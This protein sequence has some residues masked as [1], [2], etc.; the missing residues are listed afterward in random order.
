MSII[1]YSFSINITMENKTKIT[2]ISKHP[3]EQ[4]QL[5]VKLVFRIIMHQNKKNHNSDISSFVI[6][7]YVYFSYR[8]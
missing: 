5:H 3:T 7:I 6:N 8:K 4:I 1:C 2:N